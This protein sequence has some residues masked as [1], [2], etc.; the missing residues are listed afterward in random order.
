M[1]DSLYTI[2]KLN[3]Y[4]IFPAIHKMPGPVSIYLLTKKMFIF[5]LT[6]YK[7]FPAIHKMPGPVSI[8]LLTTE[9]M[10]RG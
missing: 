3:P 5:K 4:K 1:D 2:F 8:Y 7:I 9:T 6:P 10:R